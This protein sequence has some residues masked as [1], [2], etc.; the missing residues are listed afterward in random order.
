MSNLPNHYKN[1]TR[2]AYIRPH[3]LKGQ[4]QAVTIKRIAIEK[5]YDVGV[6]RKV[7]TWVVYFEET[8]KYLV[9]R[10]VIL[11]MIAEATG[12]EDPHSWPG[13]VIEL[14]VQ[15][16]EH[17]GRKWELVRVQEATSQPV[18]TPVLAST[19]KAPP[20]PSEGNG[21]KSDNPKDAYY[22][23]AFGTLGM[24]KDTTA[25]ILRQCEGDFELALVELMKRHTP[26]PTESAQAAEAAE[27]A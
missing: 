7:D 2:K 5:I 18:D 10:E 12:E 13:Q 11:D 24:D 3:D 9:G 6:K 8:E 16:E 14:F 23:H 4:P 20:K 27:K 17:G 15:W 19:Q 22:A 26:P 21:A 1:M 25:D